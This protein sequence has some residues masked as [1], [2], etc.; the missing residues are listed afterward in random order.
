[1]WMSCGTERGLTDQPSL[2]FGRAF[3]FFFLLPFYVGARRDWTA[4]SH[5]SLCARTHSHA[6]VAQKSGAKP[7]FYLLFASAQLFLLIDGRHSVRRVTF[8]GL[9]GIARQ[10][11]RTKQ[12]ETFAYLNAILRGSNFLLVMLMCTQLARSLEPCVRGILPAM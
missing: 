3:S 1:M 12:A 2:L 10:H 5:E 4:P 8:I 7:K 9:C 6:T 11:Y